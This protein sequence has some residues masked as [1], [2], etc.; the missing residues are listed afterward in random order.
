MKDLAE[1]HAHCQHI[2]SENTP[3]PKGIGEALPIVDDQNEDIME[4][5]TLAEV[6]EQINAKKQSKKTTKKV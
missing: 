3:A 6:A 1:E 2:S 4:A 5:N